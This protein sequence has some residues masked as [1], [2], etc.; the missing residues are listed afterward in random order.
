MQSAFV[1]QTYEKRM[2][3]KLLGHIFVYFAVRQ[4]SI[5]ML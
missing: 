5:T 4:F 1:D 3:E 2:I